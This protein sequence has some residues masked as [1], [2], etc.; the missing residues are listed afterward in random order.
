MLTTL[1]VTLLAAMVSVL[2]HYEALM[3]IT[4]LTKIKQ[5]RPRLRIVFS[6]V[7]ALIAHV[8]EVWVFTLGYYALL[9]SGTFGRLVGNFSNTLSDCAYFSFSTY[10][11][12]GFGDITP[13]G[14][15][16][17]LAGMEALTGLVLIAWTASYMFVQMERLWDRK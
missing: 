6:V 12:L 15:L 16:R 3:R 13:T 8:A 10:T 1:L 4:A 5:I 9:N 7:G 11:S 17:F 2:V 14:P